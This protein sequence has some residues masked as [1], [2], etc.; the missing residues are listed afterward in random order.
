M[1]MRK[2]SLSKLLQ[3][4]LENLSANFLEKNDYL[5][6][7]YLSN[8]IRNMLLTFDINNVFVNNDEN[9]VELGNSGL[10]TAFSRLEFIISRTNGAHIEYPPE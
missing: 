6:I 10:R 4:I 2:S 3:E 1:M 5:I 8:R 7:S 9:K